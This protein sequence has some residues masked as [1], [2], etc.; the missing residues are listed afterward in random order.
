MP[1]HPRRQGSTEGITILGDL[2]WRPWNGM[3]ADLWNVAGD[4]NG[5]GECVSEAPR[6]V[7]ALDQVGEGGPHVTGSPGRG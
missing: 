3:I 2:Q 1:F 4:R 5:R 6:L 7:V